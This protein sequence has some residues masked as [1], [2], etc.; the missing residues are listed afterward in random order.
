MAA[1]ARLA[2]REHVHVP[3]GRVTLACARCSQE[4]V[5]A[6]SAEGSAVHSPGFIECPPTCTR[7]KLVFVA[8]FRPMIWPP[9]RLSLTWVFFPMVGVQSRVPF[10]DDDEGEE[11]QFA[12]RET[13][14]ITSV[15]MHTAVSSRQQHAHTH[16]G[17]AMEL[18]KVT[19][20][21]LVNPAISRTPH[22][23]TPVDGPN[24]Q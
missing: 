24:T 22:Q 12:R 19:N 16:M 17:Q 20:G 23:A 8:D 10:C 7:P 6:R 14:T 15:D 21:P 13:K 1:Q 3:S 2:V 11:G 5:H 18:L 9:S 4:V